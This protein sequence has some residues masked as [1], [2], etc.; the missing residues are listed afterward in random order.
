MLEDY[1]IIELQ[2]QGAWSAPDSVPS[3]Y[4]P[5]IDDNR[6]QIGF[7]IYQKTNVSSKFKT[8]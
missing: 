4:I 8:N 3:S 6:K 2:D 5:K 1:A 7:R